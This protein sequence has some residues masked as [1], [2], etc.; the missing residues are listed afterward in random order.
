MI[1]SL[2]GLWILVFACLLLPSCKLGKHKR[3][4]KSK[5]IAEAKAKQIDSAATAI[6][7]A[8][9][10]DTLAAQNEALIK[11]KSS[12]W[13]QRIDF[14][15]LSAK[16]KIHYEGGD[17]NLDFVAQIR[18]QKDSV[19]W[20]SVMVAGIVQVARAVITP[21]SF[22]AILYTERTA[23]IGNT[24]KIK[25]FLPE[26]LDFFSLQNLLL[27]NP[28]LAKATIQSASSTADNWLFRASQNEYIEQLQ[29]SRTDSNLVQQQLVSSGAENRSLTQVLSSFGLF[30]N[31]RIATNRAINAVQK[32]VAII[33]EMELSNIELNNQ[34]NFP[35]SIPSNYELK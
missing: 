22:K 9:I 6:K 20:V 31:Q 24:G 27:G 16:A 2:K 29:Y 14:T 7:T 33:V 11:E 4:K 8:V 12:I 10:V 28:I 5:A 23:Y 19:I 25:E 34:M 15:T 21:D 1:N 13:M 30:N 35:F 17:K 32:N 18:M 26:G 3:S